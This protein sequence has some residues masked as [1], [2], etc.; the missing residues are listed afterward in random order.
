M[1]AS[2]LLA[3][4]C[5]T[6]PKPQAPPPVMEV[7]VTPVE[8]EDI[9]VWREWVGETRGQADIEI[10]ARVSGFLEE[11]HFREGSRIEK[12]QLLYSIDQSE[13]LQEVTA[14]RA[15][16]AAAQ[17]S[18]A[19]TDSDVKRYRPLA[20]INA[21]SQRDLD[22]AVAMYDASVAQVEAAEALVR[23]QEINLSYSRI[24]A[25]IDG[26]IGLSKARVGD[27]VG[28]S[29]NPVVLN[30]LSQTDP[31]HV[32]FPVGEQE[33]LEFARRYPEVQAGEE[34]PSSDSPLPL[35]L[36]LAD[37][38]IHEER[39]QVEFVE[40]EIDASTGT[41]I[42]EASFRNPELILRPGQYGRVRAM[43]DVLENARLVPQRAV[44]ELQGQYSV[45]VVG[46]GGAV[47]QRT[48]Q[49]GRRVDQ[50]WQ[51]REGLE[52]GEVVVVDGLQRLRAGVKVKTTPWA[53]P[54]TAA[55]P[56][57]GA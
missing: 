35:E 20:E 14:A 47:E 7:S 51:V 13:L 39:G 55:S 52:P 22:S 31:I 4:A 56:A 36:I 43:V 21:V 37:G 32:R 6:T 25:P 11:I 38:S 45:W 16:L 49:M 24:V 33:Y 17:T 1:G 41:L 50:R 19:Y 44:L 53:P 15:G 2:L 34:Q 5:D 18:L 8:L 12:G 42:I 54:A 46:E 23:L 28:Q 9:P 29:P 10:R 40:R 48:V 27:Y 30:T 3:L 57:P 26:V